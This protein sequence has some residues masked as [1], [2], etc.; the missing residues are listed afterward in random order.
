MGILRLRRGCYSTFPP[1]IFV[2][3]AERDE[4]NYSFLRFVSSVIKSFSYTGGHEAGDCG[5]SGAY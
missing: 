1:H 5:N 3:C 4:N 2:S